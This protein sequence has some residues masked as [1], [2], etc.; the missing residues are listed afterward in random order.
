MILEHP[1]RR[2]FHI[3]WVNLLGSVVAVAAAIPARDLSPHRF[4]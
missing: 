2:S 3:L 1:T 4:V